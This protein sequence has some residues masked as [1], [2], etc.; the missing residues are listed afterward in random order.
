[1]MKEFNLYIEEH[2]MRAKVINFYNCIN[3]RLFI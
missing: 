1:M 3:L 2:D